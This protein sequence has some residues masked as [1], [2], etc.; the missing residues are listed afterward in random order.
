MTRSVVHYLDSS[1]FGG[2][3]QV[4]SSLLSETDRQ[5]WRPILYAH[6]SPGIERLL[7]DA[8]ANGVICRSVPVPRGM[9]DVGAWSAFRRLL[10]QDHA[11]VFHAH[12]SWPLACR[13]GIAAA[14]L[15]RIPCIAATAHLYVPV[16]EVRW[17]LMK[18]HIQQQA[19]DRYIAVSR[20]LAIRLHS[21]LGVPFAKL[22]VVQ[23]GVLVPKRVPNADF[24]LRASL[25]REGEGRPLVLTVA[26]LHEQKGHEHLIRA[27][28]LVPGAFFV[29]AGDGPERER[30]ESLVRESGIEE[31]VRFLG[32]RSDVGA[33]LAAS[34]L[35][36]LPSLY[37][38]LPL[39]VLEA[40]AAG[41]PVIATSV[42]GVGEAIRDGE[43]GLLV[44]PA[45]PSA[46]AAAIQGLL[47]DP[48][49]AQR[50]GNA[51]RETVREQFSVDA[52]VRGVESVY[53]EVLTAKGRQHP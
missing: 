1:T 11:S 27:A 8:R 31:R 37:E 2:V 3:E 53:E 19:I 21:D 7:S 52:M 20:D 10:L 48:I 15:A 39:S 41:K 23:N 17:H 33:L 12:L 49:R 28:V 38:G 16:H 50:L 35:V 46:L 5:C 44:R 4:V 26:R 47:S 22:R 29:I 36:V 42:G 40:M 13:L 14:R 25:M 24:C 32:Q 45:D 18:Q 34:D 9:T 51:G 43:S 30:L 6:D